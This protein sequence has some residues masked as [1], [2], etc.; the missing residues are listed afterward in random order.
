MKMAE[1]SQDRYK[2]KK[3]SFQPLFSFQLVFNQ[4]TR[5]WT[6]PNSNHLQITKINVIE[7]L[8]FVLG[9]VENIMGKGENAGYRHFL[10]LPQLFQKACFSSSLKVGIVC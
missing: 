8:K 10:V 1:S 3:R 7:K 4:T 2:K 5:F 9:M 6:G